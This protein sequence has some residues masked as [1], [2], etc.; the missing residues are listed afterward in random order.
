MAKEFVLQTKGVHLTYKGHPTVDPRQ[1]FVERILPLLS[2]RCKS[3]IKY[4][5]VVYENGHGVSEEPQRDE[6]E[7][8]EEVRGYAHT[9]VAVWFSVRSKFQSP[10]YFDTK[11]ATDEVIHPHIKSIRSERHMSI[12]Y[13]KYHRKEPV[14][15][16]QSVDAPPVAGNVDSFEKIKQATTLVEACVAAGIQPRTVTDIATIR[17]EKDPPAPAERRFHPSS[18]TLAS[19]EGFRVL[20]VY[21]TSG[22]GKTEWAVHQFE[23]PL[24]VRSLDQLHWLSRC[25][26]ENPMYDGFILDDVN[27]ERLEPED[28]IQLVEFERDSC[29]RL[30]YRDA[31][32]PARTRRIIC[33]NKSP[34]VA[35]GLHRFPEEQEAAVR[36]RIGIINVLGNTYRKLS[37]EDEE[38][39][40]YGPGCPAGHVTQ[41]YETELRLPPPGDQ[42]SIVGIANPATVE[43]EA[44]NDEVLSLIDSVLSELP[45][46]RK[47][48][49]KRRQP[50]I[51]RFF[52]LEAGVSGSEGS[53]DEGSD[54][55][56]FGSLRS[57][58]VD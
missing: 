20:F 51:S 46:K 39:L 2:D 12:I 6:F 43:E 29:V 56:S 19:P 44:L 52:E 38:R 31:T 24:L 45:K 30:R 54:D 21:G 50:K 48:P 25:V 57:F 15:L 26:G 41:A 34:E 8:E 37:E 27:L 33:S 17:N 1:F 13:W 40:S 16:Y 55:G 18:F 11:V 10:R 42:G 32:I 28:V 7:P 53:D 35:F 23:R 58:I 22:T 5:S 3:C 49:Q 4:Y 9:H 14:S 47:K 36:R